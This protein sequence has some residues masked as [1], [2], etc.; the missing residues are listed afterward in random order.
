MNLKAVLEARE[1]LK[2]VINPTS[3]QF[4]ETF[5]RMAGCQVFLKPEN[6]QKTGSFKVRGAYNKM[7]HLSG[8]ER[9]RGIVAHSSGNH[10]QGVAYAAQRLG[11]K[12]TIVMPESAS[13][14]KVTATRGYGA[15][16]ILYGPGSLE[17]TAKA[18]ELMAEHG[19]TLVPP[20]DD[21]YI[22][23]G[24][25]T[26][27]LE[28][29]DEIPDIDVIITPCSGGG[30]LSGIAVAA[31]AKKPNIRVY[32]VQPENSC[33][34]KQSLDKG[35]PVTIASAVTVADGL[36]ARRPG[37]L[38]FDLVKRLVEDIVLV[39]EEDILSAHKLLLERA[40]LLVEPSGATVLA[41][42]L[43]GKVARPGE[44][45]ALVLSGG[46]ANLNALAKL[47]L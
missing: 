3:L 33:A 24:Q 1:I 15:Q 40:K 19:Y 36:I 9:T 22:I 20:F 39:S 44:K 38:T 8:E 7:V 6:L 32:G 29:L 17:A 27:A 46:N 47:W 13:P 35:E 41:A 23:A 43:N 11:L 45:V 10:A 2:G 34:M 4:S 26:I 42:L 30:L 25:G 18:R 5:S 16:V 12:A 14:P 21:P 28:I 37:N 31:K